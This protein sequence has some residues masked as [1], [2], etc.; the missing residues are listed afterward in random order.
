MIMVYQAIYY[1][2]GRLPEKPQVRNMGVQLGWNSPL[3]GLWDAGDHA[4]PPGAR[5]EHGRLD[6]GSG[7]E[8]GHV[9]GGLA[10][11]RPGVISPV[12][13]VDADELGAELGDLV[14]GGRQAALGGGS[15]FSG[16]LAIVARAGIAR[17]CRPAWHGRRH[18]TGSRAGW[19]AGW[20]TC[21]DR[22]VLLS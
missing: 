2:I 3:I 22:L 4:G 1:W 10:L 21:A 6:A 7:E 19:R 8:R 16:H 5:F 20:R 11:A 13:R 15:V 18:R 9:L 14:L 17:P 12:G